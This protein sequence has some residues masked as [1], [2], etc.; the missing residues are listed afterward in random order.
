MQ[1]YSQTLLALLAVD[2]LAA[3]IPGP[4]FFLV[5]Q[6][7]L[8]SGRKNVAATV[9]GILTGNV[10]WATAVALG[11]G[12]LFAIVPFLY[13]TL[14]LAGGIYLIYLGMKLWSEGSRAIGE[15]RP[16]L[17]RN[18]YLRGF[19]TTMVNPK[20]LLYFGSVFTL[21]LRPATP[22]S[23][24]LVAILIVAFNTLLWYGSVAALFSH[25]RARRVCRSLHLR[26]NRFA[27]AVLAGFGLKLVLDSD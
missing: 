26:I 18:A 8:S 27:G 6:L 23:V 16:E 14:K 22:A 5:S 24:W 1:A 9:L 25:E 10:I 12:A 3:M 17:A 13:R 2:L 21:L 19:A 4:N 15:T 7:A 11:L 20:C